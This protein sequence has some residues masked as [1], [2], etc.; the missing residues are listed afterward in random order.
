M[1]AIQSRLGRSGSHLHSESTLD[2]ANA[3]MF[4]RQKIALAVEP[5]SVEPISVEPI[6]VIRGHSVTR[7]NALL[8]VALTHIG[9][10]PSRPG[11]DPPLGPDP[12]DRLH[13]LHIAV[14]VDPRVFANS[15]IPAAG[16]L[17]DVGTL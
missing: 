16:S 12:T 4:G 9:I 15:T 7:T 8:D 2:T 10:R 11:G 5:I 1:S 17:I 14:D 3:C 13:G 6:S